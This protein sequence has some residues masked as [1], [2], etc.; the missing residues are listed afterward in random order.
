MLS[1]SPDAL[2]VALNTVHP[3]GR[4]WDKFT[5]CLSSLEP[6]SSRT[7]KEVCHRSENKRVCYMV[8]DHVAC[9]SPMFL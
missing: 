6:D 1:V 2:F 4:L 9:L 3:L 8:Y 5:A 7:L